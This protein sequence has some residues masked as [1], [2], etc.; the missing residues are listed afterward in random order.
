MN[1]LPTEFMVLG[2]MW[3][4]AV[5]S[6]RVILPKRSAGPLILNSQFDFRFYLPNIVLSRK[7]GPRAI[8]K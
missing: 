3:Y 8:R 7:A 4:G 1:I 5:V 6:H 2:G